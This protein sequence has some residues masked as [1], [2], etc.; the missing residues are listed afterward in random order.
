MGL[1]N[2]LKICH[3]D[4][5]IPVRSLLLKVDAT[6]DLT[7]YYPLGAGKSSL[8]G[9][10]NNSSKP[11]VNE[12]VR[13]VWVSSELGTSTIIRFAKMVLIAMIK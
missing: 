10:D 6:R 8:N 2:I 12:V 11:I 3:A 1:T 7:K 5:P 13:I 4:F 9:T